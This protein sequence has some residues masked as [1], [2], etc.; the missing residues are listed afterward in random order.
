M[1]E[2]PFCPR[3]GLS[4]ADAGGRRP[5]ERSPNADACS[6]AMREGVRGPGRNSNHR[7]SGSA[8][9]A[10][11]GILTENR[12]DFAVRCCARTRVAVDPKSTC[13]Q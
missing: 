5:R 1:L 11:G 8:T 13:R 2:P 3:T 9:P 10:R 7:S 4:L 12:C 6:K